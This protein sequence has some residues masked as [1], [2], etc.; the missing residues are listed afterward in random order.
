MVAKNDQHAV[1]E[2]TAL[3][4]LAIE[5]RELSVDVFERL[6][7]IDLGRARIDIRGMRADGQQRR[8]ER[9]GVVALVDPVEKTI[10]ERRVVGRAELPALHSIVERVGVVTVDI[11]TEVMQPRAEIEKRR[12]ARGEERS[13]STRAVRDV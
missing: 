2:K 11:E 8:Q 9:T 12:V 3:L 7:W 6:F 5:T 4:E 10:V 13:F 1:I